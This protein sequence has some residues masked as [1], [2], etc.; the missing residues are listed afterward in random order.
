[1]SEQLVD[2]RADVLEYENAVLSAQPNQRKE[3]AGST[4]QDERAPY[5]TLLGSQLLSIATVET[6]ALG[7]RSG[8]SWVSL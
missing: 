3:A 8:W 6:R 2:G 1:M 5:P 7:T 4:M